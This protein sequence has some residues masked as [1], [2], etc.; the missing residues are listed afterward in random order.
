[1][2]RPVTSQEMQSTFTEELA[3]C[4]GL[5][6]SFIIASP[7][8]RRGKFDGKR[9]ARLGEARWFPVRVLH[10]SR[11]KLLRSV[12]ALKR[13]K[14][15]SLNL[16]TIEATQDRN[17]NKKIIIEV[18]IADEDWATNAPTLGSASSLDGGSSFPSPRLLQI[19]PIP[20]KV[21]GR[22]LALPH[23]QTEKTR[24]KQVRA[25]DTGVAGEEES[26][27]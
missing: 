17:D 11:R 20:R 16:E 22:A 5:C 6:L 14:R 24:S 8:S 2:A 27:G 18:P 10:S 12:K 3:S 13:L 23:L 19:L 9:R 7:P 21:P 4:F 15:E 1:M 25:S 26:L